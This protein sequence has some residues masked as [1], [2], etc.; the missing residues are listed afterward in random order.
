[1]LW[2]V[3]KPSNLM[4]VRRGR[5]HPR[6]L[7]PHLPARAGLV[8]LVL[9][10]RKWTRQDAWSCLM[11][12]PWWG[13]LLDLLLN[14]VPCYWWSVCFLGVML[15]FSPTRSA[16]ELPGRGSQSPPS[17]FYSLCP[18]FRMASERLPL[19]FSVLLPL[20]PGEQKSYFFPTPW[21]SDG[22]SAAPIFFLLTPPRALAVLESILRLRRSEQEAVL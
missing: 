12:S 2:Q 16:P 8:F 20:E 17:V 21:D 11:D 9:E 10:A 3:S 6:T 19:L 22:E 15:C 13:S 18:R 7:P 1:M 5:S 14:L 4:E